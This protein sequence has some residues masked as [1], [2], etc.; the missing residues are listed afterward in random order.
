MPIL[1]LPASRTFIVSI[2][3]LYL[4]Y[5]HYKYVCKRLFAYN[6]IANQ[7]Q[8]IRKIKDRLDAS[9]RGRTVIHY[10]AAELD[11]V[12]STMLGKSNIEKAI[13]ELSQ[14]V[15]GAGTN[16]L[17][18][19]LDTGSLIPSLEIIHHMTQAMNQEEE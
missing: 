15:D 13:D 17:P 16:E 4:Y 3:S 19:I 1:T 8:D 9:L 18:I 10:D 2:A 11:Y 7:I 5:T 14:W 12:L 6:W